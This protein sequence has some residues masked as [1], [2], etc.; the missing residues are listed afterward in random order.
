MTLTA[1]QILDR[2]MSEADFQQSVIE[3][4]YRTGWLVFHLNDQLLRE[5]VKSDRYDALTDIADFPDLLVIHPERIQLAVIELKA[6]RG[7]PTDGQKRWLKA[8]EALWTR[9]GEL[10]PDDRFDDF[11]EIIWIDWTRPSDW[12]RIEAFLKG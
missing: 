12:D 6:Q 3:L 10:I 5:A 8:F 7:R 11:E 4:A 1:R 2:S 9:I